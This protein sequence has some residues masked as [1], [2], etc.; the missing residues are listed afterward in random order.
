MFVT[1]TTTAG[2]GS[3]TTGTAVFDLKHM[4]AKTGNVIDFNYSYNIDISKIEV[5]FLLQKLLVLALANQIVYN[6]SKILV[7]SS[8]VLQ[9]D[10]VQY[11]QLNAIRIF[12][13]DVSYFLTKLQNTFRGEA[14]FKTFG[15]TF[16]W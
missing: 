15:K 1:V 16:H 3:E 14:F 11:N 9:N 8:K 2:T 10:Y 5:S 7:Y 13:Q 12:T 4:K 6:I